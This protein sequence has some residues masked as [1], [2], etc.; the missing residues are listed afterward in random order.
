MDKELGQNLLE[1]KLKDAVWIGR[2]LFER[3]KT[4]GSSANMSFIHDGRM[5]IS[6]SGSC[7]GNMKED[8]FAVMDMDGTCLSRNKPSKEWPLHLK[9][10]RKN[11]KQALSCIPTAPM[12]CCGVLCLPWTR[13]MQSRTIPHI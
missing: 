5:Y 3:N 10:Y 4:A 13:R 2:S 11:R 6:R 1:Q 12:E 9:V 8:D 7:F